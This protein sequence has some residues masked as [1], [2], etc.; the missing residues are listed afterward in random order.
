MLRRAGDSEDGRTRTG[1]CCAWAGSIG[2]IRLDGEGSPG[3]TDAGLRRA[4]IGAA[5]IWL[6]PG[7]TVLPDARLPRVA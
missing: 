4:A 1:P 6:W 3:S 2:L 7:Q 5:A